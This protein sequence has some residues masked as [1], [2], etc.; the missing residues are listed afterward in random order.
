M[1]D[2]IKNVRLKDKDGNILHPEITV[3]NELNSTS[4]NPVQNKVINAKLDE[5]F[6]SVSNGKSLLETAITD[7]G[8]S[9]SKAGDVA[10]FEELKTGITGINTGN[11]FVQLDEPTSKTGLWLK[12]NSTN[13]V[14]N[15][16]KVYKIGFESIQT[17]SPSSLFI[18]NCCAVNNEVYCFGLYDSMR[19]YKKLVYKYNAEANSYIKLSNPPNTFESAAVESIG[20]IIYIM[21]G[22]DL[23]TTNAYKYDTTTDTYTKLAD[24]PYVFC[25]T[26]ITSVGNYIYLLG[27]DNSTYSK[28]N[29]KYDTT[30]DTY[31]KLA[32]APYNIDYCGVQS[33]DNT[34]YIFGNYHSSMDKYAYKYDIDSSTYTKLA[35]MPRS[36]EGSY[37]FT[38]KTDDNK[39]LVICKSNMGTGNV[40]LYDNVNDTYTNIIYFR[41]GFGD[42][43]CVIY[44][45]LYSMDNSSI[46]SYGLTNNKIVIYNG[47]KHSA[48]ILPSI[49]LNFDSIYNSTNR[50]EQIIETYIG[51]GTE[52]TKISA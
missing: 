15:L 4:E 44:N 8:S 12:T 11:I 21:G 7:K 38:T 36:F 40:Y 32:D 25:G 24:I 31:T 17:K 49:K 19:S 3:D 22:K 23:T 13:E 29:Y 46:G 41:S 28:N 2:T 42:C 51:N 27:S 50:T 33:V 9:V 26:E 14:V 45:T 43:G 16:N 5:V 18:E 1:S 52:W 47:N 6:Q 48:E 20:N 35:D 37:S 10:T 39:I 34:I 30:T